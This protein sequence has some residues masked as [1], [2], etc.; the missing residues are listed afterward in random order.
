MRRTLNY[1]V[2]VLLVAVVFFLM[3][4]IS[5]QHASALDNAAKSAG[6]IAGP[7]GSVTFTHDIAPIMLANCT[8]CHRQGEI[9]P[10]ALQSYQDAK[11]RALQFA[12]VTESRYMPPWHADS[13]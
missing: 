13:H 3:T 8:S 10:F 2:A 5:S 6:Y 9:G 7:K 1:T 4:L 12:Q 11:K